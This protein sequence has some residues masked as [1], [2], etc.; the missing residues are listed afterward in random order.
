MRAK[1][2]LAPT[3]SR[4]TMTAPRGVKLAAR[5]IP[6]SKS[7]P[8]TSRPAIRIASTSVARAE[9]M[10]RR[11]NRT[12]RSRSRLHRRR[13]QLHANHDCPQSSHLRDA[14]SGV[15]LGGGSDDSESRIR[16]YWRRWRGGSLHCQRRRRCDLPHRIP[17]S[18]SLLGFRPI[19]RR[20]HLAVRRRPS[21]RGGVGRV[22][23]GRFG[24]G[25]GVRAEVES[26]SDLSRLGRGQAL[27]MHAWVSL[28]IRTA[29][30]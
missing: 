15:R 4:H 13:R 18:G 5:S 6:A 29:S 30:N 14:R 11:R 16:A 1:T 19:E 7:R 17:R 24:P 22:V 10:P 21:R 28:R 9:P 20:F 25:V 8:S 27:C 26:H 12:R 2:S 3:S 23:A